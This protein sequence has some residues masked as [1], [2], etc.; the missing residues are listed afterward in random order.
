M[1]LEG[2]ALLRILFTFLFSFY[3]SSPGLIVHLF[4]GMTAF[5][6]DF[7]LDSMVNV[8]VRCPMIGIEDIFSICAVYLC[9]EGLLEGVYVRHGIQRK[10]NRGHNEKYNYV[11]QIT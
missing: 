11:L 9:H 2:N 8:C 7:C 4:S 6:G 5:W 3:L 10:S 1:V